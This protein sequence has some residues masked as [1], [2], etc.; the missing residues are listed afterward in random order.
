VSR[1]LIGVDLGDA[2]IGL[3]VGD[4]ELR[5]SLPLKVI[6]RKDDESDAETIR[7]LAVDYGVE[8]VVLGFPLNMDGSEGPA[9]EKSRRFAQSLVKSG[10]AV[11]FEDE[12]LT[13]ME[14]KEMMRSAGVSEKKQRGK[15][16]MFAAAVILR[17][18]ISKV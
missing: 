10:L 17:S 16:D 18:Y 4:L 12:R 15:L 2:R 14:A 9:C 6:P 13:T 5:S 3:A 11:V 7:A 8:T 1:K